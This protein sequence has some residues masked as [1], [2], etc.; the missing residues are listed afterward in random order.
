[1]PDLVR[2]FKALRIE[3]RRLLSDWVLVV[4][5]VQWALNAAYHGR[6][7]VCRYRVIFGRESVPTFT[8]L[9]EE[10][11]NG[12]KVERLDQIGCKLLWARAGASTGAATPG[13]PR[14]CWC[15]QRKDDKPSEQGIAAD[16]LDGRLTLW[17]PGCTRGELST[18]V[19]TYI[20]DRVVFASGQH[21]PWRIS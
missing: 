1:M 18:V 3:G 11:S 14:A 8:M 7:Q 9:A 10:G 21:V 4:P 6:Y 19:S 16:V 20:V 17:W 15:Q 12:W 5:M 13:R 2:T